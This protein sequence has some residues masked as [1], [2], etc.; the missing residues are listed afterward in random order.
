LDEA[1]LLILA[2]HPTPQALARLLGIKQAAIAD[3]L[4]DLSR[5][6]K[7]KGFGV[8]RRR[9]GSRIVL[10]IRRLGR[11]GKSVKLTPRTLGV[12]SRPEFRPGLKPD[13]EVVYAHDW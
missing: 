12:R 4:E 3:L 7:T 6:I 9:S 8:Y 5:E 11:K 1:Y 10:V 2:R 13:D